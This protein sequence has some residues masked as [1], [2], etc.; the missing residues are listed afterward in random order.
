[1]TK[2]VVGGRVV[3]VHEWLDVREDVVGSRELV[4]EDFELATK[5]ALI[6]GVVVDYPLGE[7]G[8]M[9][10][11]AAGRVRIVHDERVVLD[12]P[13]ASMV[14]VR[15]AQLFMRMREE[16]RKLC[17][18]LEIKIPDITPDNPHVPGF[19]STSTSTG[20]AFVGDEAVWMAER[21]MIADCLF[22]VVRAA[23][24]D[25]NPLWTLKIPLALRPG[26]RLRVELESAPANTIVRL[27][28][29]GKRDID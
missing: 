24:A 16:L 26:E 28:G 13:C 20:S 6:G 8:P 2:M 18:V 27:Y 10:A 12:A 4:I 11:S 9:S 29:V 19:V 15:Y 23:E 21:R 1:M 5:M 17:A 7:L 22:N 14:E 25:G 3:V